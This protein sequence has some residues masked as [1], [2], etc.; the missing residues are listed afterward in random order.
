[1]TDAN[2]LFMPYSLSINSHIL[3]PFLI[4]LNSPTIFCHSSP[5]CPL[6]VIIITTGTNKLSGAIPT[7]IG[8]LILLTRLRLGKYDGCLRSVHALFFICTHHGLCCV[9]YLFNGTEENELT[10][11]IPIELQTLPIK[12]CYLGEYRASSLYYAC[13][14]FLIRLPS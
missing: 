5:W 8:E 2:V 6:F 4:A 13:N 11:H 3:S 10:G 1:M 9:F 12:Y 14:F 7:E